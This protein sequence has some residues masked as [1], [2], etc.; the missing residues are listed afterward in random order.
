M[1]VNWWG[2]YRVWHSYQRPWEHPSSNSLLHMG[3]LGI[4]VWIEGN[5]FITDAISCAYLVQLTQFL[6]IQFR[7]RHLNVMVTAEVYSER[8]IRKCCVKWQQTC[9]ELSCAIFMLPAALSAQ[10]KKN[11]ARLPASAPPPHIYS[12]Y[13]HSH[14]RIYT[15]TRRPKCVV[16]TYVHNVRKNRQREESVELHYAGVRDRKETTRE[17]LTYVGG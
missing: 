14:I 10:F 6:A 7:N 5:F 4:T 11:Q 2:G 1:W 12:S 16:Y 8:L 13:I 9:P 3:N 17:T 15:N